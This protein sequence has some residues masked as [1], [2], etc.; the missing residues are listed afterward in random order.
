MERSSI[1][2]MNHDNNRRQKVNGILYTP[3]KKKT[4]NTMRDSSFR[5]ISGLTGNPD[6]ELY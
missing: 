3:V 1:D 2:T 4:S 5:I 6:I